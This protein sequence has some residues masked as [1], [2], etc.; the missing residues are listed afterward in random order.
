MDNITELLDDDSYAITYTHPQL[1]LGIFM[2]ATAW[3][4]VLPQIIQ[5]HYKA[6]SD[7]LSALTLLMSCTVSILTVISYA[8]LYHGRVIANCSPTFDLYTNCGQS[9]VPFIPLFSSVIGRHIILMQWTF[10]RSRHQTDK[11]DVRVGFCA[12]LPAMSALICIDAI[13]VG[14]YAW[15]Y[16][17]STDH[18]VHYGRVLGIIVIVVVMMQWI[19]QILVSYQTNG[20][21]SLSFPWVL[22]QV[23]GNVVNVIFYMFNGDIWGTTAYISTL[24]SVLALIAVICYGRWSTGT[25]SWRILIDNHRCPCE[26]PPL[27]FD[28]EGIMGLDELADDDMDSEDAFA[29]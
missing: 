4:S 1:A 10:F 28:G 11:K 25:L 17:S 7:G 13:V 2:A 20:Q 9:L 3:T 18:L 23:T 22:L 5:L 12:A 27:D 15:A 8:A 21:G 6:S 16:F 29:I 26:T 14:F 19:P 24:T